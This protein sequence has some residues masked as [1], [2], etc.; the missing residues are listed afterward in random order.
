[1]AVYFLVSNR[2]DCIVIGEISEKFQR[3]QSIQ[4]EKSR[5]Q[6]ILDIFKRF[7]MLTKPLLYPSLPDCGITFIHFEALDRRCLQGHKETHKELSSS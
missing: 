4:F 3:S 6:I 1:M 2:I 7:R 5:E